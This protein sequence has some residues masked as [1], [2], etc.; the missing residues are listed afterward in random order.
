MDPG[1]KSNDRLALVVTLLGALLTFAVGGALSALFNSVVLGFAVLGIIALAYAAL[2]LMPNEIGLAHSGWRAERLRAK[3]ETRRREELLRKLEIQARERER[4]EAIR[5]VEIDIE[6][7]EAA[8]AG[9]DAEPDDQSQRR[10][11][12]EDHRG[13]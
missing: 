2:R 10:K 3:W 6:P 9:D 4:E 1:M 8:I 11:R 12:D 13:D 7:P 5:P